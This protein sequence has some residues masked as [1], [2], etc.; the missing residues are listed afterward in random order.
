MIE[1]ALKSTR[2]FHRLILTVSLITVVFSLSL[3]LPEEKV[4]QKAIIDTLIASDFLV[5]ENFIEKK[6]E[7][8]S[9]KQLHPIADSISER[10]NKGGFLVFGL[11]SIG[12]AFRNS[13]HIG[14]LLTN[15]TILTNVAGASI[16]KL[17]AL[18]GWSLD[19]DIQILVP[20]TS[21]LVQEIEQF[22]KAHPEAGRRIDSIIIGATDFEFDVVS[23][24]PA[25]TIYADI[26][27]ELRHS[28]TPQS[29]PI[30]QGSFTAEVHSI[31]NSSFVYWLKNSSDFGKAV[32]INGNEVTFAPGLTGLPNGYREE[33]LGKI[34]LRLA[35]DI[36]ESAPENTTASILGTTVP[37]LLIVLASPFTLFFLSYYLM[38]H[39][40]H[41]RQLSASHN[42]EFCQFA[43][44]PLTLH[45]RW[46][47]NTK[48]GE[49]NKQSNPKPS[50]TIS[51]WSIET[52]FGIICLPVG[53]LAI[54]Y[55]QLSQFDNISLWNTIIILSGMLSVIILGSISLFNIRKVRR[56]IFI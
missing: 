20:D 56:S 50:F 52:A 48:K 9:K 51:A 32:A 21:T 13:V 55:F 47:I 37:G 24:L 4:R 16:D 27:F 12:D 1:D 33:E 28:V 40:N 15:E 46:E 6:I 22:L 10:L 26:Y 41:L 45:K 31:P 39:I 19:H 43:W 36:A 23:F 8:A 38:N 29:A 42:E 3:N 11:D 54:L 5:Y 18:N 14:K 49:E 25:G 7:A 30:F 34:S 44:L 35:D 2:V 53:S 17:N